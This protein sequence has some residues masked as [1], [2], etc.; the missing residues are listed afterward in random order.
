MFAAVCTTSMVFLV[1]LGIVKI[2]FGQKYL[3]ARDVLPTV[4]YAVGRQFFYMG[5]VYAQNMFLML[6]FGNAL[7]RKHRGF[8]KKAQ[9]NAW[10]K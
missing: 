2:V 9:R 1:S 5:V 7:A 3:V 4:L 6:A 10:L 8:L